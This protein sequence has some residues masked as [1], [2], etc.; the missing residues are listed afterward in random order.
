VL[1]LAF[2][3]RATN[4]SPPHLLSADDYGVELLTLA[5]REED[6]F[7]S[8]AALPSEAIDRSPENLDH[9]S[10]GRASVSVQHRLQSI[11]G[12]RWTGMV[13]FRSITLVCHALNMH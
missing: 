2:T 13:F 12:A 10:L 7:S 9:A 6:H 5:A 3:L 8:T 11:A 4:L 1:C